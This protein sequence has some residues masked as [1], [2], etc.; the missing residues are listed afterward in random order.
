LSVNSLG[1]AQSK[2]DVLIRPSCL[3]ARASVRVIKTAEESMIAKKAP[4][5]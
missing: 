3:E 5:L 1:A 4:R 2:T